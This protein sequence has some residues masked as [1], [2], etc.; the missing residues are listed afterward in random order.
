[1]DHGVCSGQCSRFDSSDGRVPPRFS[2]SLGPS[3][4]GDGLVTAGA[5]RRQKSLTDQTGGSRDNDA[6]DRALD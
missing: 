5:Q 4:E 6:H 3:D 2:G 1:M